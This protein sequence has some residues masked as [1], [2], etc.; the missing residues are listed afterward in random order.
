M[1]TPFSADWQKFVK[2]T[3]QEAISDDLEY[4]RSHNLDDMP[5]MPSDDLEI[6]WE[7]YTKA[8]DLRTALHK[9]AELRRSGER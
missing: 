4:V 7:P 8:D 6:P 5:A 3:I 1:V 2:N 9:R